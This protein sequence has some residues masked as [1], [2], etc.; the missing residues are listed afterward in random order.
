[1]SLFAVSNNDDGNLKWNF[2][3]ND[4]IVSSP[5]IGSDGTIYVGSYDNYLYA[6]NA[7]GTLK[8]NFETAGG[9]CYIISSPTIVKDG[10]IYV[11]TCSLT[12]D[13]AGG[14]LLAI[15]SSSKGLANS[16]WPKIHKNNKN[17]GNFHW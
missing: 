11:T 12:E 4:S 15:S 8:W 14:Y 1:M 9:Y 10:T 6:I 2:K 13:G 3:T 17:T 5:A 16:A 7:D